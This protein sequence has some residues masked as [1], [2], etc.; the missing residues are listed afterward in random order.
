MAKGGAQLLVPSKTSLSSSSSFFLREDIFEAAV[1]A[2]VEGGGKEKAKE[3]REDEGKTDKKD[4][5]IPC[6]EKKGKNFAMLFYSPR[7]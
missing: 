3:E 7:F 4:D 5:S 2:N 1:H 6:C